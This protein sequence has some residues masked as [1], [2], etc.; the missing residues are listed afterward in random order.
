MQQNIGERTFFKED[1]LKVLRGI[2]SDTIDLIYLDPP[3]NTKKEQH[4]T[5]SE[6]KQDEIKQFIRNFNDNISKKRRI[7]SQDLAWKEEYQTPTFKDK[8]NDKKDLDYS[9]I[10]LN[11]LKDHVKLYDF[12]CYICVHLDNSYYAYL[13]FMAV[14][15]VEMHRVLKSTGALYLHCDSK[16][17]HYLKLLLDIIFGISNFRNEIT[18]KRSLEH[19]L[20]SKSLDAITDTIFFYSKSKDYYYTSSKQLLSEEEMDEKFPHLE[21]ETDRRYNH[22]KLEQ[23]SNV[24][25]VG[26]TRSFQGKVLTTQLGWRWTQKTID[27]RIAQNP[28]LI[29]WTK[30]GRPRYKTYRDEYEGRL[31]SNLWSDIDMS[32]NKKE[33]IGYPT[34]KPLALLERIIKASSKE[35]DLV[36]DPFAGCATT[37]IAAEKLGRKWIGID[38]LEVS[39]VLNIYR[40]FKEVFQIEGEQ[41]GINANLIDS[42]FENL[43]KFSKAAPKR[44]D[45]EKE[46]AY[47]DKYVYIISNP[48]WPGEYKVGIAGEP[49]S[50]LKTY[51]TGAPNRDYNLIKAWQ[52]PKAEEIER[53]VHDSFP[54][55]SEW[56][57]ADVEKIKSFVKKLL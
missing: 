25:N 37:C 41:M 50:R 46:V 8:W 29:Y 42:A 51:Q 9:D 18:W 23:S 30:N 40:I 56:V 54:N 17:G 39:Y 14:R 44:T 22:Q 6:A 24:Y 1:N 45:M 32:S 33:R 38:V 19:N 26:E 11:E 36:L 28:Y 27:E 12:L 47:G 3:F 53:R 2:N 55:K 49:D 48:A 7:L 20:A 16:A 31:C 5:I 52:T 43:P 35:G 10:W 4:S 57:Q 21:E 15:L 34:Q 13:T